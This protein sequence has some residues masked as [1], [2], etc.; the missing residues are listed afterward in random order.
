MSTRSVSRITLRQVLL[1][2]LDGIVHFRKTFARYEERAGGRIVAHFEDG[3]AAEGEC[4]AGGGCG[5]T[6]VGRA[7]DTRVE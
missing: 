6:S 2:G 7:V 3:T 4:G 5:E 1:S